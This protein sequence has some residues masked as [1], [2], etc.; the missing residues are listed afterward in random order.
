MEMQTAG[1]SPSPSAEIVGNSFVEQYYQILHTAPHLVHKFYQDSSVLSRPGADSVMTSVTTTQGI[2]DKIISFDFK[3]HKTEIITADAQDSYK[4]GVIVL[5]TGCLT[6]KD[7]MRRKFTQTF[8]LARQDKGYYVLNDVFRFVDVDKPSVVASLTDNDVNG[9]DP[10]AP[11]TPDPEPAHVPDQPLQSHTPTPAEEVSNDGKV[12]DPSDTKRSVVEV[13]GPS[14]S[15]NDGQ[16]V[17]ESASNVQEDDQKISYASVLAKKGTVTPPVQ[18]PTSST[19]RAASSNTEQ[20]PCAPAA[21]KAT[22]PRSNSA[23][24]NSNGHAEVKGIYIGNLPADVTDQQLEEVFKVF[25]RIKRDGIQIK[26][27]KEDGFCFGFVEFESSNS[28]RSAIQARKITIGNKDAHIEEKK[29]YVT[30]GGNGRGKFASGRGGF[31]SDNIKGWGWGNYSGGRG[32]SR[33]DNGNRGEFSGQAQGP[34]GRNGEA[35]SYQRGFQNDGGRAA[36]QGGMK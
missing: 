22:A 2:N 18:V 12:T 29:R 25:G 7:N 17:A 5:V 15:Q 9:N 8:F 16:S 3:D 35:Y 33:Y 21:P 31:R 4:E 20:Q 34:T 6:G 36:R 28:A 23:L 19:V 30:Q 32:N 26:K 27:F 11:V 14:L 13:L 10:T 1:P 24:Q